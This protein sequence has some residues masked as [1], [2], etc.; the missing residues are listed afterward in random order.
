M[1]ADVKKRVEGITREST[2]AMI[3]KALGDLSREGPQE[4]GTPPGA[5]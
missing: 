2:Q 4:T 1:S 3:D 5:Q